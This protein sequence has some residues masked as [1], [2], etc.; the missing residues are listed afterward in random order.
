MSKN[1]VK[2]VITALLLAMLLTASACGGAG[3]DQQITKAESAS[4]EAE[5]ESASESEAA[6]S[7][8]EVESTGG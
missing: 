7:E 3:K 1:R 4:S 5:S 8:S 2:Q 6:E